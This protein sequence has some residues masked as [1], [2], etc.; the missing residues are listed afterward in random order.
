M[1]SDHVDLAKMLNNLALLL[2]AGGSLEGALE[3]LQRAIAIW[4]KA[5]GTDKSPEVAMALCELGIV[6]WRKGD[7]DRASVH[8]E[9]GV[10]MLKKTLGE[11]H[12]QYWN[13]GAGL[14]MLRRGENCPM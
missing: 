6:W 14:K 2:R 4:N 1:G 12:P 8:L 11:G 7:V 10:K 13:Y 3:A 9:K 5:L